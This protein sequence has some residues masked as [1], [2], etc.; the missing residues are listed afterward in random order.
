M[1][2][3]VAYATYVGLRR[4]VGAHSDEVVAVGEIGSLGARADAEFAQDIGDVSACRRPRNKQRRSDLRVRAAGD[5]QAQ[6]VPLPR[7]ESFLGWS[8]D[9]VN[10]RNKRCLDEIHRYQSC[11]DSLRE[12]KPRPAAQAA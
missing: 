2:R 3:A 11:L 5:K 10:R 12:R 8:G 9:R 4:R 7:C 1:A 6:N